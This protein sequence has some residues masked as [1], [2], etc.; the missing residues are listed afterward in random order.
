LYFGNVLRPVIS[1]LIENQTLTLAHVRR[2]FYDDNF[3]RAIVKNL[4]NYEAQEF[5]EEYEHMPPSI[6]QRETKP[7]LDRLKQLLSNE[8][9]RLILCQK[10]APIDLQ[11]A[12]GH[13]L[14]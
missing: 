3:R 6:Q 9:V 1:T 10:G 7:F 5:W 11:A 4:E 14:I 2:L 12:I 8:L 13:R